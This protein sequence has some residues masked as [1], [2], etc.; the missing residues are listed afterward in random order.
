MKRLITALAATTALAAPAL[1]A[2]M[3]VRLGAD[4]AVDAVV[5]A[6]QVL[7][8]VERVAGRGAA[9]GHVR[10]EVDEQLERAFVAVVDG[11]DAGPAPPARPARRGACR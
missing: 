7:D 5:R 8:A 3:V 6:D 11:V 10:G 1:A 9:A 4:E 2:E